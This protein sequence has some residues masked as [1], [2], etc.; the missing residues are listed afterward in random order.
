[1][2]GSKKRKRE[3]E[4]VVNKILDERGLGKKPEK[5]EEKP[6]QAGSNLPNGKAG[7]ELDEI[8]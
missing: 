6:R 7:K 2:F 4:Q 8:L 3:I 5:K 1:M